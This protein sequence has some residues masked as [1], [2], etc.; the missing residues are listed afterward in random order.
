[1]TERGLGALEDYHTLLAH[2]GTELQALIE[3]VVVPESWFFRDEIPFRLVQE[4]AQVGWLANPMRP[5]LRI[6]SIPCAGGE[7]PYSLAIALLEIGL[8]VERSRVDAVDIS[9]RR[10]DFARRGIFTTNAFRGSGEHLR[11]RYFRKCALGFELD[12]PLRDRVQFIQGSIL[13]PGLLRDEAPYHVVFCRNLL[14]YLD[15]ASRARVLVALDRLLAEDGLLVIGHADRL[16]AK[17]S[18]PRFTPTGIPGSFAYRR[19]KVAGSLLVAFGIGPVSKPLAS[20]NPQ[21]GFA[22][23]PEMSPGLLRPGAWRAPTTQDAGTLQSMLNGTI[24]DSALAV[25]VDQEDP[26][27]RVTTPELLLGRASALANEGQHQQAIE[28]CQEAL[29][30]QGPDAATYFL[31]GAIYQAM[32]NGVMGEICFHKAVYLDPGH[33]EALLALALSAE[34]RGELAAAVGFRRRAERTRS[35][36]G[37]R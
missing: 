23:P 32:G 26:N 34:R 13:D 2:S 7:E 9:E 10:L 36:K 11:D 24:G 17:D 1:M 3:E 30:L 33:D 37:S 14:I 21:S 4:F 8:A 19:A 6:L 18:E 22:H 15:E 27:S 35:R 29:A 28:L 5:P 31:M 25:K 20:D 16:S 12:A